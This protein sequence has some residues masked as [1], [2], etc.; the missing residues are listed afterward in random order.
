[1]ERT[2]GGDRLEDPPTATAHEQGEA[3]GS[4]Q[5]V[6]LRDDVSSAVHVCRYAV[7]PLMW[8]LYPPIQDTA[9]CP[10]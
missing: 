6:V 9:F 4:S 3:V 5:A 7:E 10:N 1:M 2:I 8:T